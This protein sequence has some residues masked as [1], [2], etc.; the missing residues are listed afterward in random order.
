MLHQ[1]RGFTLSRAV[2]ASLPGT[3]LVDQV[4]HVVL[5]DESGSDDHSWSELAELA[6]NRGLEVTAD[7]LRQLPYEVLVTD[8]I[9]R[10]IE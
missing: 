2:G 8:R 9:L 6:R 3:V 4:L 10:W 7:Q 1:E 5:L